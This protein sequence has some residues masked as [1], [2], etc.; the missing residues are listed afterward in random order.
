[1]FLFWFGWGV[2]AFFLLKIIFWITLESLMWTVLNQLREPGSLS[3]RNMFLILE[4]FSENGQ[5]KVEPCM[6]NS[7]LQKQKDK[8]WEKPGESAEK[9]D[10]GGRAHAELSTA[11]LR[12][13]R[14]P[15][16][17]QGLLSLGAGARK[18]VTS[19]LPRW[20]ALLSPLPTAPFQRVRGAGP[21][22]CCLASPHGW[23]LM[24]CVWLLAASFQSLSYYFKAAA[25]RFRQVWSLGKISQ[26]GFKRE[27]A[28][29]YY[30]LL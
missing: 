6:L 13:H 24:R 29:F 27:D 30:L 1:M 11:L 18:N 16:A 28:L 5:G 15:A 14:R 17:R 12:L 9:K 2:L 3:L 21:G 23:T 10:G 19:A 20:K 7:L 22:G 26:L 8:G 4:G 25:L